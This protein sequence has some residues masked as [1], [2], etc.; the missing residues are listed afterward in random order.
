MLGK[1][2]HTLPGN[3]FRKKKKGTLTKNIYFN[4][5]KENFSA[6]FLVQFAIHPKI[7]SSL[8][9]VSLGKGVLKICSQFTGEHSCRSVIS[10]AT[11]LKSHFN[12]SV[13]L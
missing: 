2:I 9:K 5:V 7:R 4:I 12:M 11:L 10:I 1:W 8:P 13:L 3:T 6:P